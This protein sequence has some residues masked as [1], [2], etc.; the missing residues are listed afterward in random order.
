[1]RDARL[2]L[3]R[4]FAGRDEVRADLERGLSLDPGAYNEALDEMNELTAK[5]KQDAGDL[6]FLVS[7]TTPHPA[8]HGAHTVGMS[9]CTATLGLLYRSH[10]EIRTRTF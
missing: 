10:A 9:T 1:M 2:V 4:S 5:I 8:R 6:D 3:L 7:P